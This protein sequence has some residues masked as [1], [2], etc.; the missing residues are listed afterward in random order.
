MVTKDWYLHFLLWRQKHISE[1]TFILIISFLIGVFAALSGVFL[2]FLIHEIHSLIIDRT[3]IRNA[4]F[5]YLVFPALGIFITGW[6]VR[7][8]VKDDISHGVTR[9]LYAFAKRNSRI[10]LHNTYSSIFT[11]AITIG[12]GGSVGAEAPIV[13]TGAAIGSNLGRFFKVEPR[14]LMLLLGCGAAA[15]ISGI[16]K[17][18]I[19]GMVFTLEVLMLDLTT[20]SILPLLISSVTAVTVSYAFNGTDA[21]FQFMQTETFRIERIPYVL[22]LGIACGLVS[23]YFTKAMNRIEGVFRKLDH[24]YKKFAFGAILLSL[25]IFLLPPLYGEGYETITALLNNQIDKLADGSFFYNYRDNFWIFMGYITLIILCKVFAS[26]A[27][28]GG[29]GVGGIFAPSLFLGAMTGFGFSHVINFFGK[30]VYL[31]EK[32]F[33]L[34][35]MAG[36]MSAV[37]HA[38]LTGIFLIAELTGGYNLFLPLMIVSASAFATI[39]LFEPNNIYAMRLAQKGELLTHHKDKTVLTLLKMDAVIEKDFEAVEPEM[40]LSDLVK[41]I[42]RSSRN[43]YPVVDKDNMMLGMV[44]LDDIRNIMFRPELYERF[45]VRKLMVTPM[46][47]VRIGMPMEKVMKLFDATQAWNLPVVDE[48]G[49]YVGFVSKSKIFNSYRKVLVHYSED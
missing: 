7:N 40:L 25:L 35:G 14:T 37:M 3:D 22:L 48:E 24:P 17:S 43:I 33:A 41:V 45:T 19:A 16:F 32:N 15:A 47:K 11:S 8:I 27:T 38:P 5:I 46:A 49:H 9:I 34:M 29:G 26:A 39:K 1:R 44:L 30:S 42:S 31:P 6:V 18:P 21:M 28:N 2:K 10:K 13:Y 20:T 12:F 23:L 4:N 36:I